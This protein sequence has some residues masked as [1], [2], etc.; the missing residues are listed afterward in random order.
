MPNALIEKCIALE[1]MALARRL[2]RRMIE[3]VG[4]PEGPTKTSVI[5]DLGTDLIKAGDPAGGRAL[6][7][8]SRQATFALPDPEARALAIQRLAGT[9]TAAGD[10]D[11]ALALLRGMTPQMQQAALGCIF[12]SVSAQDRRNLDLGGIVIWFEYPFLSPKD[13]AATRIALPK[14]AA[15]ARALG[16]PTMQAIELAMIAPLQANSGDVTGALATARSIP[17]LKRSDV[18]SPSDS[19]HKAAKPITFA[20]IAA[21]QARAGDQSAAVATLA[22][23]EAIARQLEDDDQKLIAQIVIAQK[24]AACGRR[25]DA[26]T[27]ITE[28]VQLARTQPEPRRSRVLNMLARVQ[29]QAGDAAGA[30]R[31]IEAIRDEPGLE[32]AEALS[33]LAQWHEE[34]GD[35]VTAKTLLRRAVA[36]LEAKASEKPLPGKLM[37][38]NDLGR[39]TFTQFNLEMSPELLALQRESLLQDIRTW[40]G[41]VEGAV[42]AARSLPPEERDNALSEVA[43]SLARRGD[44]ARAME[45]ATSIESPDGRM[46]AF[47]A[48]AE[49]I[50]ERP[51]KK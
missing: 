35:R 5:G 40:L 37:A 46:R 33:D 16:N 44:I 20:A 38:P 36:Y 11:G 48:L 10:V 3:A 39:G 49:A 13:P 23:A 4:P 15:A 22:E 47:I 24:V 7:E 30:A 21:V 31:T 12:E 34:A 14:L 26:N 42:R 45:M 27:I 1:D 17:D 28:A 51:A 19:F 6:I 29:V 9:L 8:R 32:K 43:G 18:P 2:I 25:D 41:D 50:S